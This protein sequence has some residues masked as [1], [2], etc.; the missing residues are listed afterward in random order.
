[1]NGELLGELLAAATARA[2]A[3]PADM[4]P[5]PG[6]PS[7]A[8]ALAGRERLSL[9]AEWKRHSPSAGRL[10]AD[11]QL[12][13]TIARYQS[14]G[15]AALSIL[16]EP[17][18]FRGSSDDLR[19]AAAATDLPILRKD[20]VVDPRQVLEA[21][22][23]GASAVLLILRCL[24]A[25]RLH[26]LLAACRQA[27][28]CPLL[29]CHDE[30]ELDLALAVGDAAIGVNNRDLDTLAVD[31]GTAARLLPR[32]PG[33]RIAVAESGYRSPDELRPLLGRCNGVLI[34]TALLQGGDVAAFAQVHR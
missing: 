4:R 31:L 19:A 5:R 25:A 21:A 32:V 3:L 16:T 26:E 9:I 20:C 11:D 10:V 12:P 33:D 2:N 29:E 7:F 13:A 23:C 6:R 34:G 8:R 14:Y 17:T 22:A 18:R 15:A 1:M 27:A 30:R 24:D 28:I